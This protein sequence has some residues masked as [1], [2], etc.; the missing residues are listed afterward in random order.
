MKKLIVG[1][2]ICVLVVLTIGF[3]NFYPSEKNIFNSKF[4]NIS[5]ANFEKEFSLEIIPQDFIQD[6]KEIKVNKVIS[7]EYGTKIL[8]DKI[9]Y[10]G[11]R[12]HVF[13]NSAT[14]WHLKLGTCL[15]IYTIKSDFGNRTYDA[16][17][18]YKIFD[19]KSKPLNAQFGEGPDEYIVFS[20][21]KADFIEAKKILI[22][23]SGYKLTSYRLNFIRE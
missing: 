5:Q 1:L 12:Y 20:F 13:I 2:V 7:S 18:N 6:K 17:I 8:F 10:D 19:D 16:E 4:Y 14:R 9:I 21:D 11:S 3:Y 23:L 22:K 15:S